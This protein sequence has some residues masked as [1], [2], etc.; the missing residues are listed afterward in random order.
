MGVRSG[1]KMPKQPESESEQLAYYR[2]LHFLRESVTDEDAANDALI[3]VYR[4][5]CELIA[6]IRPFASWDEVGRIL[7]ISAIVA[8]T[9]FR[10]YTNTAVEEFLDDG[11]D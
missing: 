10:N 2:A 11:T 1:M 4:T 6:Q 5:Q 9:R 8:R 7:G 3:T